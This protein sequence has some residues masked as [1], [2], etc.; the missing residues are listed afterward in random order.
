MDETE[1]ASR[2]IELRV[3]RGSSRYL[4]Q[5]TALELEFCSFLSALNPAKNLLDDIL[6]VM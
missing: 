3:A 5:K 2:V 4:K 1:I 6:D